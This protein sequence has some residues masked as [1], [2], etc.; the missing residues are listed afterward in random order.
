MIVL[1]TH[2]V[3]W[4]TTDPERLGPECSG[5]LARAE[6]VAVPSICFWEV[7]LLVRRGRLAL[8]TPVREWA[9]AVQTI[10]RV[11]ALPLTAETALAADGLEMHAD[12]CDRF[13]VATAMS[14]GA[15]LATRDTLIRA[16]PYVRT[17]W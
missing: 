14:F 15:P 1:D 6:V 10:P 13:I 17:I 9:A 8:S 3:V 11:R 5:A 4:W 7:A 2:A 16:L 12:P